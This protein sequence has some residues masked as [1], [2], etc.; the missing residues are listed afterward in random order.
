MER[1]NKRRAMEFL[2]FSNAIE[3]LNQPFRSPYNHALERSA[4]EGIADK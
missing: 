2:E 3:E 4:C 1:P